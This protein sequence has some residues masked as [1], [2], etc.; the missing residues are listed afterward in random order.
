MRFL[1]T[2]A[3][4]TLPNPFCDCP[5]CTAIRQEGKNYYKARSCFQVDETMMIDFGPDVIAAAH[6]FDI[7]FCSLRHILF[8]HTHDDHLCLANLGLLGMSNH[9]FEEPIELYFSPQA[10]DWVR[11][12]ASSYNPDMKVEVISENE[13]TLS[14]ANKSM[15]R[16]HSIP[17]NN[18]FSAGN[19]RIK[20]VRGTHPAWGKD[21]NAWNYLLVLP[22]GR[23][24]LYAC[25]TGRYR[26]ETVKELAEEEVDILIMECTFGSKRMGPDCGH[27]DVYSFIDMLNVFLKE[28]IIRP[29]TQVYSTHLNHKH[30]FT[31]RLLQQYFNTHA[32]LPVTVAGDGDCI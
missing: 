19:Y 29:D 21:E 14:F 24:L 31:P 17:C 8:T 2:G 1:G 27:L 10:F 30:T 4:E 16:V 23:K 26:D 25:D 15:Y 18:W 5:V 20:A 9:H 3:A 22:D 12:T 28:K 13:A 7:D 11:R 6:R 32:P